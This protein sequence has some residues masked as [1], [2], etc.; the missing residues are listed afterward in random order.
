MI[1]EEELQTGLADVAPKRGLR[2]AVVAFKHRDFRRF[3]IGAVVSN[4]GTWMQNVTVPYVIYLVTRSA[5]MV[6]LAAVVQLS[7]A[8]IFA[9]VAG[10]LADRFDR[11]RLLLVGQS[12]QAVLALALWAAWVGHFRSTPTLLI[13]LGLNGIAFGLTIPA[14]QAFVTELVPRRDLLNAITLNS[15][16]FNAAR[17][18]GPAVAGAILARFG[19]SWAFLVNALSFLAVI[20]AL[21]LVHPPAVERRRSANRILGQFGDAISYTLGNRGL[22]V[23]IGLVGAVFFFGN[24]VFQLAPV[25][26]HRV[27]HVGAGLYGLLTAGYGLGAVLGSVGLGLLG[28]RRRRSQLVKVAIGLYAAGLAGFALAP[29]YVSGFAFLCL[30]GFA[31]LVAVATLNTSVQL[32][33]AEEMRGRVLAIYMMAVTGG[34]PLG[35]FIQGLMADRI[36]PRAT[37]ALAAAALS[38]V[39]LLLMLRPQIASSLER[40]SAYAGDDLK[41]RARAGS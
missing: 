40:Q 37:V 17:A 2:Q 27:Y 7:P 22:V 9:P 1:E 19:P 21:L 39:W 5:T 41:V 23:G 26:A 8:V 6:G 32:L 35:S 20:G 4:M 36:G 18:I 12:A 31:F 30:T 34:Y 28:G 13:L 24:P 16:Q 3:W 29:G 10:W 33:V 38:L 14:W 11:R 25:F 15:A